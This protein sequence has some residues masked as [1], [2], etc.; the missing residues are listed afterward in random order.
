MIVLIILCLIG[1]GTRFSAAADELSS[2]K[3]FS[4]ANETSNADISNVKDVKMFEAL[5]A[6]WTFFPKTFAPLS[7][8]FALSKLLA[9]TDRLHTKT[10]P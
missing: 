8:T 5:G 2:E 6:R 1:T 9:R 7:E 3:V 4:V 10:P